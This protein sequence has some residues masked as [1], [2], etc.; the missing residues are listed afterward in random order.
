M[1]DPPRIRRTTRRSALKSLGAVGGVAAAGLASGWEPARAE[2]PPDSVGTDNE[3]RTGEAVEV[4]AALSTTAGLTYATYGMFAFQPNLFGNG[5]AVS[6]TGCYCPTT[7]GYVVTGVD[8]PSG[9]IIKE[10]AFVGR[11]NSSGS[12]GFF[13]ERYP[14]EGPSAANQF[15]VVSMT[16]GAASLRTVSQTVNHVV[17]PNYCYDAGV[18]T[19]STIRMWSC[20]IGYAGPFGFFRV[21]PQKRKLDT[22]LPG[23][24]SGKFLTGQIKTL[25]LAPD[26]PA[27]A[28]A[29]LLNITVDQT[30]GSGFVSLFPDGVWP[31]TSAI[32]W[33][34]SNQTIANNAT[35][36]VSSTASVKIYCSGTAGSKTHVIIDLLGYLR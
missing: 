5:Y 22:R 33:S 20:R 15:A 16:A 9:A 26:V 24:Q 12:V 14:L 36:A 32:N 6:G 29:A 23:P 13:L 1:I 10:V 17:D 4:G 7:A 18:F 11:N 27:G 28:A 2:A 34:A 25:A 19:S 3:P 21:D 35:V 31:G 30:E 8:L